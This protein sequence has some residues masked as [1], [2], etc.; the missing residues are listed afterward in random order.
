MIRLA[1]RNKKSGSPSALVNSDAFLPQRS[2]GILFR[3]RVATFLRRSRASAEHQGRWLVSRSFHQG[4][5]SHSARANLEN[6]NLNAE[7]SETRPAVPRERDKRARTSAAIAKAFSI[8]NHQEG[9]F[10]PM[11][12]RDEARF[13]RFER[14][15]ER[16][17]ESD[18]SIDSADSSRKALPESLNKASG[19]NA[20]RGRTKGRQDELSCRPPRRWPFPRPRPRQ[21]PRAA[22][23]SLRLD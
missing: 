19:S 1:G 16:S 20:S 5:R 13:V 23:F 6:G 8:V 4:S 11:S 7:E 10:L 9:S 22:R 14:R 3:L 15:D 2:A 21:F 18:G 12:T 17:N